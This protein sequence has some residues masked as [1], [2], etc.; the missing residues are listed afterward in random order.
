MFAF[1][2]Y[3]SSPFFL[4]ISS[5]DFVF[6]RKSSRDFV[7]MVIGAP[8]SFARIHARSWAVAA[9]A[10]PRGFAGCKHVAPCGLGPWCRAAVRLAGGPRAEAPKRPSFLW[11]VSRFIGRRTPISFSNFKFKFKMISANGTPGSNVAN[12]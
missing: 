5:R 7:F 12:K 3:R 1:F 8:L 9:Q 10:H 6:L 2:L 11:L 4:V